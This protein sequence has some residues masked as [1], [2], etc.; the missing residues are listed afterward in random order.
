MSAPNTVKLL[1]GDDSDV[2]DLANRAVDWIKQHLT[3]SPIG[4]IGDKPSLDAALAGSVTDAGLGL[5]GAWQR[6]A[7][8]VAPNNI[9]LDSERFLA[10]IPLSPSVASVWMDTIVSAGSF[11][12]ESWLE[13]AGAVAA[14]N[15]V[16]DLLCRAAGMPAGAAGCFMSGGSIGNLSALA[17]GRERA[18]GRRLVAV[19]D[20]AHAS[21]DNALHILGLEP[22]VVP[23]GP[24]CRLTGD[25]LRAAIGHRTDVGIVVATAGSTNAGVIDDLVGCADVAREI[26]AWYHVDGAYGMAALL[27]PEL[28]DRFAGLDRADSFIVDPHKWLF[29]TGGSCALVYR[30]PQS[31][32]EVHTQ[33]GPYI[34]VL[35]TGDDAYNPCDLGYQLTRRA[36]GLP[37]WFALALHG[38][39]AH[40]T[41]IRRGIE[42]ANAMADA[43][44]DHLST[45]L[46]M[47]PELGV[48]LFRR[49]GWGRDEWKRWATDLLHSGTAFVAPSTLKGEP[50]GRLVFMHPLTPDSIIDEL[51]LSLS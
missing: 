1:H 30:D 5:D 39:D 6:F 3:H 47:R 15:Q 27:L 8:I 24:D 43:L 17:V 18:G 20:T 13:G 4:V 2:G 51:M 11:P 12:A 29:A 9:G 34:D 19:A 33:H 46:I 22:Q 36:S 42:L 41:A 10:F 7:E 25:A 26:D 14:E 48:V 28:S 35:R 16:I 50:V 44:D 37:I 23:T 32:R 38:V 45:E 40:R 31:A 21:V 49:D